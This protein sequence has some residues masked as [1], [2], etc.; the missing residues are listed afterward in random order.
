MYG[1]H[2]KEKGAG[3]P[4]TTLASAYLCKGMCME[5][6][7]SNI[8]NSLRVLLLSEQNLVSSFLF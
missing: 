7:I 1:N 4:V 6:Q 8:S 2:L 3:V 5:G